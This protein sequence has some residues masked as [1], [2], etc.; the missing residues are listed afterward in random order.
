VP[1]LKLQQKYG[2]PAMSVH[3]TEAHLRVAETVVEQARRNGGLAPL[4]VAQFWVDQD[5]AMSDPWGVDCPQIPLGMQMSHECVFAELG[6]TEDW[7]RLAHDLPWRADLCRRYNDL[8][9]KIV[10]R[11]LLNEK[12]PMPDRAWP[13]VKALHDIFAAKNT[14]HIDSYW[15]QQAAGTPDELRALL[16][17]VEA[18]LDGDL[19]SFLLP[20][21]W[22]SEKAR[23]TALGEMVPL[24][25]GQRGPTTFA[26]SI[27]GIENLIFL[28][29]DDPDL[30]GRLRDLILRAMLERARILDEEAGFT[31]QT[32]PR[33]FWFFDDNCSL[34]TPD[35]YEFFSYPI[36]AGIFAEYSPDPAD[37]RYQH[38][39]S[40]M[41]HLLPLFG[42]LGM[43]R[44]NFGPNL[45]VREIREHCPRAIIEGQLAPFTLSRNEEVNIV[46]ELLRDAEQAREHRGLVFATA[47]SIN[48]GSRL[49]AMRLLMAAIQQHGRYGG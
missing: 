36:L 31:R 49:T 1:F 19:R 22:D 28:C 46:A 34:L 35:L 7:H 44:V 10:G 17:R 47:G 39:D 16:D 9:E 15:L 18:C 32:C 20:P 5:R 37:T 23:L 21:D 43:T 42:R 2:D 33:G 6:E 41:G 29:Y 8:A 12:V 40:D 14:W 45:T 3:V 48:N 26:M 4:D 27:Y 13:P 11:R 24:Y 30:A 25:R 38:S